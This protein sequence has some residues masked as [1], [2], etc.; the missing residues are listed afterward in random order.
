MRIGVDLGGTNV[1]VGLVAGDSRALELWQEFGTHIG[2]LVMLALYAYDPQAIVF[3]GSI[4]HAFGFFRDAMYE[5]LKRFPYA[6]TVERLHICCSGIEY[7][8]LL[9]ASACE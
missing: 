3:G 7:V 5:Q 4:S 1:R 2:Q 8:G 6:K 9:G